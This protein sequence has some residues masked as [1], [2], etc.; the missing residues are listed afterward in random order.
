LGQLFGFK[1]APESLAR[2]DRDRPRSLQLGTIERVCIFQPSQ[3]HNVFRTV[4]FPFV[5]SA[6]FRGEF[7]PFFFHAACVIPQLID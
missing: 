2:P 1:G 3:F 6:F 5:L 7:A 4:P